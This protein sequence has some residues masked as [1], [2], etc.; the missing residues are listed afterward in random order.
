MFS[1]I[2]GLVLAGFRLV[3]GGFGTPRLV[4]SPLDLSLERSPLEYRDFLPVFCERRELNDGN[5]LTSFKRKK[6]MNNKHVMFIW[7][8]SYISRQK[9][10]Q[11][12]RSLILQSSWAAANPLVHSG[13]LRVSPGESSAHTYDSHSMGSLSSRAFP[14]LSVVTDTR[15]SEDRVLY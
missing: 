5:K 11:G 12:L 14:V 6:G 9:D 8:H 13:I 2:P 15:M 1:P 4:S 10:P 3:L 7:F